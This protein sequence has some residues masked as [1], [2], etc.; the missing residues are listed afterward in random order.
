M[1]NKKKLL[2]SLFV[3][4]SIFFS[5]CASD[6][7]TS[8][9]MPTALSGSPFSQ[10][11]FEDNNIYPVFP[12][13]VTYL[14]VQMNNFIGSAYP[15]AAFSGRLVLEN[16]TFRLKPLLGI[17][18]SKGTILVWPP[19]FSARTVSNVTYITDENGDVV[20]FVG[21]EIE[22]GGG[23]VS[24]DIVEKY[25]G[26]PVPQ[27]YPAPY[28]LVSEVK[29]KTP[30]IPNLSQAKPYTIMC[31]GNIANDNTNR[32]A[33]IWII[34]SSKASNNEEWAQTS[35]LAVADL[36]K[37][38]GRVFTGVSLAAGTEVSQIEYAQASYASDGKG[39]LGMT[40]SA[41]AHEGYWG[42]QAATTKLT[43]REYAIAKIW[44]EKQKDFPSTDP[45]SSLSY[46]LDALRKYTANTLGIAIEEVWPVYLP[47]TNYLYD[48]RL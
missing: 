17:F 42:V 41:P 25:T 20:A 46:D 12:A 28:W 34:T 22:G 13:A 40:G 21:D 11:T 5:G 36:Q 39:A 26:Q 15:S 18:G 4:C 7:T 38:C 44:N 32:S 14:P 33:G 35:I 16:G 2:I 29:R 24:V 6:V 23:E 31:E 10:N 1:K 45:L 37:Q 47:Y 30:A 9:A 19:G 48:A 3:I 43:D 8:P 27:N